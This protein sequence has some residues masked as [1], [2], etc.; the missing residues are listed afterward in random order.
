[1]RRSFSFVVFFTLVLYLGCHQLLAQAT[2]SAT[3]EGTVVDK[4]QA[5]VVGA[6]VALTNKATGLNR[7]TTT[8]ESGTY[9]FDLLPAGVYEI[10]V[11][12]AGFA[13]AVTESVGLLVGRT[14]T[15]DFTL[16]PGGQAETVTITSEAPLVDSQ[17]SDVGL[18]I[19]PTEVRDLP[20]NGR[21]FANL[22]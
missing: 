8:N 22:A 11:T 10:R 15:I 14:T 6:T 17:K 16:S 2:A 9:R 7:T 19:T 21:D 4:A 3:L 20:L 13:S 1:M 5:V 18:N 12:A